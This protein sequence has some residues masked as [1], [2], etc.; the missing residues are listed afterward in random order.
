[1]LRLSLVLLG[2]LTML[3]EPALADGT[4][5]ERFALSSKREE[6]LKE[7]I[8]GTREYY[9]FHCL[10]FQN[11]KQLDRVDD[12]LTKWIERHKNGPLLNEIQYRQ[13]VLT[14]DKTPEKTLDFIRKRRD[15]KFNH[16]RD[17]LLY[18][19]PSPRD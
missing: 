1:M 6:I 10:H 7:L 19:S 13:A 17:C 11:T 2:T 4:F 5:L 18:T 15:L 9:Y 12:M 8:P 3:T 14:Y 16:Q